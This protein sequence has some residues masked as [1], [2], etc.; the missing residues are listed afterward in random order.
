MKFI[1][2]NPKREIG[3]HS[4]LLELGKFRILIDAG[5]SPKDVGLASLPDYTR[6]KP[7]SIDLILLTHCHLDHIGSLPCVHRTQRRARLLMT[8]ASRDI[9]PVMLNNSY[10]VML[11]QRDELQVSDY[12]LFT[13]TEIDQ[14]IEDTFVM[15]YGRK[16][17]FMKDGE[18]LKVTFFPA[19]HVMGAAS[20]LIEH[21]EQTIF[22]TG[23]ILFRQQLT[24]TGA[25]IPAMEVDTL[26][27]ET[28][29]GCAD[30]AEKFVHS[31]EAEMLIALVLKTLR[32]GGS[33]LLPVFALGRMQEMLTLLSEARRMRLL[34]KA[35]PIYCSGLGLAVVD[36]FE[37]ISRQGKNYGLNY[38]AN[39]KID[40]HNEAERTKRRNTFPPQR[41]LNF[42]KKMLTNLGVRQLQKR[43]LKPG[44]DINTPSVFVMSSGM[45]VENTPANQVA[46]ALLGFE[47][48]LIAF[49]GYCDPDTP[50]G[51]LLTLSPG[52]VFRF[53]SLNY[54]TPIRATVK[55]FDLSGH[56][57]REELVQFASM[58]QPKNIIL[59]HG[60][61]EAR[62]RIAGELQTKLP[63]TKILNPEPQEF[64]IL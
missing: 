38:A 34:P 29:R 3:A 44:Q 41:L 24:L 22:V 4:L 32:G 14:V 8:P 57:D 33:C 26:I 60:E 7:N 63:S 47:H 36:V 11:R 16:R 48:N 53:D 13:R 2:L 58:L 42:R 15:H 28:T 49:S 45:L 21:K 6:L 46:A 5:I 55:Q 30:R 37:G 64:Y 27:T 40:I 59:S 10:T 31:E 54:E 56:A 62:E 51:K 39:D 17:E 12:P 9:L 35:F 52:D 1:D 20:L 61:M 18:S 43:R 23:D 25:Q 50:G 19:G